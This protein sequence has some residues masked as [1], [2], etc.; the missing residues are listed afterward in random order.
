M[1]KEYALTSGYGVRLWHKHYKPLSPNIRHKDI[2]FR[3]IYKMAK[4]VKSKMEGSFLQIVPPEKLPKGIE[5]WVVIEHNETG[6]DDLEIEFFSRAP[7]LDNRIGKPLQGIVYRIGCP[8][9]NGLKVSVLDPCSLF[10]TK[11][12]AYLNPKRQSQR[13]VHDAEHLCMLAEII[14]L[15]LKEAQAGKLEQAHEPPRPLAP[16]VKRLYRILK[17]VRNIP[18]EID[19][20]ILLSCLKPVFETSTPPF[21]NDIAH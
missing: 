13:E 14:P 7:A 3:A 21:Y 12:K 6:G 9:D 20:E 4:L 8:G 2:D 17:G 15:Y 16:S 1:G 19:K 10:I 18:K 11:Y 5:N